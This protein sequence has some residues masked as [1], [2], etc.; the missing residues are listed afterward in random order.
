MLRKHGPPC[1]LRV[2]L[3]F[4]LLIVHSLHASL[5]QM[6]RRVDVSHVA[7]TKFQLRNSFTKVCKV[8]KQK[9]VYQYH[10]DRAS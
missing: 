6:M 10:E 9:L 2:A 1:D 5:S 3:N 8:L 4:N 7:L